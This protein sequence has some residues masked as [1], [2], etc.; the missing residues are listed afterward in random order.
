VGGGNVV[1]S[2]NKRLAMPTML[3]MCF[4]ARAVL[5][6][7]PP[8]HNMFLKFAAYSFQQLMKCVYFLQLLNFVS[9][10][11]FEQHYQREFD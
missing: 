10:F 6:A 3:R 9:P 4:T 5:R 2:S 8:S 7:R 1:E 11:H